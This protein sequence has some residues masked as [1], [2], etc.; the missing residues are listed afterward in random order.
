MISLP[1]SSF[2]NS[3][4]VDIYWQTV[5]PWGWLPWLLVCLFAMPHCMFENLKQCHISNILGLVFFVFVKQPSLLHENL[6]SPSF[7]KSIMIIVF[8]IL[9]M[10]VVFFYVFDHDHY[11][12]LCS[13]NY[14]WSLLSPSFVFLV[15]W[16]LQVLKKKKKKKN[17][18][19]HF[20]P[21]GIWLH[22]AFKRMHQCRPPFCWQH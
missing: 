1:T 8:S 18:K 4:G 12:L 16:H 17:Q 13:W 15:M 19:V 11:F 5:V 6:V 20:T 21:R 10:V 3:Y 2:F 14:C 7:V 22:F 9:I